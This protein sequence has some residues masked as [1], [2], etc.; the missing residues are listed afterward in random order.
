MAKFKANLAWIDSN[1]YRA[2]SG[3]QYILYRNNWTEIT[4]EEDIEYFRKEKFQEEGKEI[5]NIPSKDEY[6][7]RL[8]K[9]QGVGLQAAVQIVEKFPNWEYF[10]T[11]ITIEDL[12]KFKGITLA[13]AR[14][15]IKELKG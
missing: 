7:K 9:I 8:S 10:I 13:D 2:P 3:Q 15:I 4:R 14:N 12:R 11:N 5:Q 1:S 6:I